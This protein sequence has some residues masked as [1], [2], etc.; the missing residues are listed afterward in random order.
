MADMAP[1]L[2]AAL[3]ETARRMAGAGEPWWIVGS[4]AALLHGARTAVADVD[5]LCGEADARA[6][7]AAP[8]LPAA[9]GGGSE[10]FRSAV[11]GTIGAALPIEVMGGLALRSGKGWSRVTLATRE[12]V[13]VGGATLWV[14]SRGELVALLRR[15]G[16]DKDLARAALLEALPR[17]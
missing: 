17:G 4:A 5:L 3:V 10:L 15:F 14:P 1:E 16:R 12:P 6:V 13:R 2:E 9:P 8:G 7:L 11:F